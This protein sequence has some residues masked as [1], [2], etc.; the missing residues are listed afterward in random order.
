MD[1]KKVAVLFGGKS[2]EYDIS[3]ASAFAILQQFPQ[4]YE[5]VY[6]GISRE[7]NWYHYLGPLTGIEKDTWLSI[8]P[9]R[10]VVLSPS[11]AHKGFIEFVD[12]QC[13]FMDIDIV[14]P[15]LHGKNG[16][17]GSVQGL[18]QLA[19]LPYV[20]C[21]MNASVIGMD[22]VLAHT[23]AKDAGV[24]VPHAVTIYRGDC[25]EKAIAAEIFDY[26]LY[27]KPA[28][29]GSSI[30][31]TKVYCQENLL[32]A[33]KKAFLYDDKVLIEENIIG[34]EV[35][36]A[37]LGNLQP[38][39]GQIDEIE[40][41]DVFFGYAEKYQTHEATIHLP[42]RID[43]KTKAKIKETSLLLY[44]V[45]GCRGLTRVDLFL[46]PDG[47][48]VFNEVNTLPGFTDCSRY[49]R[50]LMAEHMTFGDIIRELLLLAI[51]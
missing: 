3:L 20:G 29:S 1:K 46:Q 21:D 7:G 28:K 49:P 24:A 38:T 32:N 43:D 47:T 9:C 50:M 45:F 5:A 51:E 11:P 39:V 23:L 12:G 37:V 31:I 35:G 14:F 30:G 6:I 33:V 40:I 36:C 2:T 41:G 26:P 17:D 22:K 27:V 16:E 4:D 10:Q 19:E 15:V 44:K 48:I 34:F 13:V 18:L 42:A 25:I 8:G